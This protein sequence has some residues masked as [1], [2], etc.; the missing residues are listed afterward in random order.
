MRVNEETIEEL[1]TALQLADG[2]PIC[3]VETDTVLALVQAY[4]EP[5][6]GES[7]ELALAHKLWQ[8]ILDF[9][10]P[11]GQDRCH[12][13]EDRFFAAVGLAPKGRPACT[14]EEWERGCRA[15]CDK[16]FGENPAGAEPA[17]EE[18][19]AAAKLVQARLPECECMGPGG[20]CPTC[21][22]RLALSKIK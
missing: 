16:L 10:A 19:V 3:H 4:D 21:R 2:G 6:V 13:L 9:H 14:R 20:A 11:E 17:L 12:D 1:R 15:Y 22:F 7:E 8:A 18:L 5:P